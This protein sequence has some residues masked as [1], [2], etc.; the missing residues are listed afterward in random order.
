[1]SDLCRLIWCVLIGLLRSRAALEAE[2]LVLRHQLNVLRRKSPKRLTFSSIDHQRPLTFPATAIGMRSTAPIWT[3]RRSAPTVKERTL[4]S[5]RFR[6]MILL[7]IA[8][9]LVWEVGTRS[10]VAYLADVAPEATLSL[11]PGDHTALL[12]LADR[13]IRQTQTAATG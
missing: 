11:R 7:P 4:R 10:V 6:A 9:L 2:I 1:M 13:S 3:C 8:I 5:W 12:R